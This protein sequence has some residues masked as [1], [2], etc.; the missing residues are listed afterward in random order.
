[1]KTDCWGGEKIAGKW[2]H[3][4]RTRLHWWAAVHACGG[5]TL[6]APLVKLSPNNSTNPRKESNN[7]PHIT[8]KTAYVGSSYTIL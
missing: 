4:A 8:P 3:L 1:M 5:L 7:K 2:P 6:P